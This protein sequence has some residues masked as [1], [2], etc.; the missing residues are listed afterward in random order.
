MK[1]VSF[2]MVNNESEIIESFIRYNLN[3]V[4]KM[5]IIDNGCTDNTMLIVQ[6]LQKEGLN[7]ETYDESLQPYDQFRLDNKYLSIIAKKDKPDFIIPLDADE[8]LAAEQNPREIIEGFKKDCIYYLHWK[9]YV[10]SNTDNKKEKFI[11]KRITHHL[12]EDVWDKALN[13]AVCKVIVPTKYYFD[14]KLTLTMGHHDVFG[15][16]RI[17]KKELSTLWLG[18]FK[19]IS[20][21]QIVS[22]TDSYLMRD[23]ATMSINNE[24]AQISNQFVK[25]KN[26]HGD[27][28]KIADDDFK[29]TTEKNGDI[30]EDP[31]NVSFANPDSL[32]IKYFKMA[33]ESLSDRILGTGISM[34]IRA[35]NL[36]RK[37]KEKHFLRPIVVYMD[38]IKKDDFIFPNPTN[39][40]TILASKYNVRAYLS[41]IEEVAFLKSN[42]RLIIDSKFLKFIPHE[43]VVI[44]NTLDL[45]ETKNK[46]IALG[47]NESEIVSER[48]YKKSLG[49][50]GRLYTNI[51]MIPS[52]FYRVSQYVKMNGVKHAI[53]KIKERLF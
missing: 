41:D 6:K 34:S 47:I 46:L 27:L 50:I 40:S 10:R 28:K 24:T 7:I 20:T 5:V 22:K 19:V 52:L 9:L 43:Y 29:K 23:I 30:I 11:P 48:E 32:K 2:T 39:H 36:A 8:F 26:A 4:D 15:N 21:L 25:I 13:R 44:P 12:V 1:L 51:C 38:G 53:N 42:Y 33:N 31:L 18:H 17:Q 3:I 45:N 14:N 35:Y 16:N 37:P 49:L